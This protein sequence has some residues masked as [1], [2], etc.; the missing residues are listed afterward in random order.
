VGAVEEL[1]ALLWGTLPS[2]VEIHGAHRVRWAA[3]VTD[4]EA[5]AIV[6][7]PFFGWFPSDHL[8]P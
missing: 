3:N 4:I 7:V 1:G 8:L 5:R 2:G 6:T